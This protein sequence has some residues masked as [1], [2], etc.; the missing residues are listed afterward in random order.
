MNAD[1]GMKGLEARTEGV[2]WS[3][4]AGM[5]GGSCGLGGWDGWCRRRGLHS[6]VFW[7]PM[8]GGRL[9]QALDGGVDGL[10]DAAAGS[11]WS[12]RLHHVGIS[13]SCQSG[14]E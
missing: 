4:D 3:R 13:A 5:W 8:S 7:G 14:A 2:G 9:R 1:G 11:S 12:F 10:S 6:G